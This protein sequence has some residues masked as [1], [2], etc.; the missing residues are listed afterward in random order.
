MKKTILIFLALAFI[1]GICSGQ[2]TKK[3]DTVCEAT[4]T[5]VFTPKTEIYKPTYAKKPTYFISTGTQ[6][7]VLDTDGYVNLRNEP[8]GKST[9]MTTI[10]K[11]AVVDE[12]HDKVGNWLLVFYSNSATKERWY[13][14]VH[15]S[16]L[17]QLPTLYINSNYDLNKKLSRVLTLM[18]TGQKKDFTVQIFFFTHYTHQISLIRSGAVLEEGKNK[19]QPISYHYGS[20]FTHGLDYTSCGY[21]DDVNFPDI[22]RYFFRG[23]TGWGIEGTFVFDEQEATNPI[24]TET[25]ILKAFYIPD[26]GARINFVIKE[27]VVLSENAR[28]TYKKQ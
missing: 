10:P 7:V 25:V 23:N 14:Y 16:R 2:A 15:E 1:A 12:I 8:S 9:I 3:A 5:Q 21:V 26:I 22:I 17:A 28:F 4:A 13:G 24:L 11:Y 20:P 27:D 6:F 19:A 18:S